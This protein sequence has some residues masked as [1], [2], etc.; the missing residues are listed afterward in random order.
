MVN[1]DILIKKLDNYG[2]RGIAKNFFINKVLLLT[3]L[4]L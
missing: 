4:L 3:M 2:I 1:R